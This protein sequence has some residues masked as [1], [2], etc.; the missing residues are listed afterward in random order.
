M[1][2]LFTAVHESAHGT[3]VQTAGIEFTVG[4]GG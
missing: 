4:I 3:T 1:M 2:V